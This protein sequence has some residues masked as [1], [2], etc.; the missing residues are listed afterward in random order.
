MDL[1]NLIFVWLVIF[2]LLQIP[3]GQK[4]DTSLI[5]GLVF[6]KNIAH[7]KMKQQIANPHILLLHGAIEYQRVEN[8]F[9]SLEP[10]ILQVRFICPFFSF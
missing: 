5:H 3:V 7:K 9:S 6:T 2:C 10:Q 1:R 4:Q 8:K